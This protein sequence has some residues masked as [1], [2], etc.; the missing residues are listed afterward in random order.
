MW[1]S[2]GE[3]SE[4]DAHW[5][6]VIGTWPWS[7]RK[8]RDHQESIIADRTVRKSVRPS[9]C[10]IGIAV[11]SPV[12]TALLLLTFYLEARTD[13]QMTFGIPAPE[14]GCLWTAWSIDSAEIVPIWAGYSE[15]VRQRQICRK[16]ET[17]RRGSSSASALDL[18]GQADQMLGKL[19][20]G[21]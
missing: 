7:A 5:A 6:G 16:T 8:A 1:M 12:D 4:R 13:W 11:H 2:C 9:P 20:P 14:G 17:Q 21:S 15:I 3:C 18:P 10:P 19:G